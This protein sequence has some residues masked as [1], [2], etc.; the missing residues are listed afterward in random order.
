M[1]QIQV[2]ANNSVS[3]EDAKIIIA[4]GKVKFVDQS[5]SLDVSITMTDGTKY[6]T[7]EPRVD[8]VKDWLKTCG[9]WGKVDFAQE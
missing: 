5:H 8:A 2:G 4:W 3:W 6:R 9:K 7:K 1:S